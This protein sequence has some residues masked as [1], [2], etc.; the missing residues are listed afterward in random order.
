MQ[1]SEEGF[2]KM[3]DG[4]VEDRIAQ[5]LFTYRITPQSTT[6]LS[7]PAELLMGRRLRSRFD[8]LKPTES[9]RLTGTAK[10]HS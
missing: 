2:G 4:T 9:G 7:P 6:Q 5:F 10:E 3:S 1:I 8:L